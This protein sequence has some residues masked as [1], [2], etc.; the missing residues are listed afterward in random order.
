M[1]SG[2]PPA[3]PARSRCHPRAPPARVEAADRRGELE[4]RLA[5][6]DRVTSLARHITPAEGRHGVLLAGPPRAEA[7]R[8]GRPPWRPTVTKPPVGARTSYVPVLVGSGSSGSP[9]WAATIARQRAARPAA[10]PRPDRRRRAHERQHLRQGDVSSTTSGGAAA[11]QHLDRL[12]DLD[13]VAAGPPEWRVHARE[14]RGRGNALVPRR[15]APSPPAS[16]RAEPASFMNA[17][18]PTFTSSTSAAVPSANFLDMIELAMSG[19]DSTVPVRHAV[20]RACDRPAPGPA[21]RRRSPPRRPRAGRPSRRSEGGPPARDGLHLVEACR[22]CGRGP[23]RRALGTAAPHAA[24]SGHSGRLILSP[25]PPVE[26][27]ST[28]GRR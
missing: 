11:L 5:G 17:P 20:R 1:T 12:D 26:C 22:P 23:A 13:G 18:E 25:T 27:L 28:V 19:I 15:G 2:G 10:A 24:T 6:L 14:H 21:R 8:R 9:P 4:Y 3:A 16:A 7:P